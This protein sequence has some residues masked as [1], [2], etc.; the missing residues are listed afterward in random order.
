MK[1]KWNPPWK[2]VP[3]TSFFPEPGVGNAFSTCPGSPP[4]CSNTE[5]PLKTYV[6][7]CPLRIQASAIWSI[8]GSSTEPGAGH[9]V[10]TQQMIV[11]VIFYEG[12]KFRI[13]IPM[14]INVIRILLLSGKKI[15]KQGKEKM[16]NSQQD[17]TILHFH[18]PLF[19]FSSRGALSGIISN[20]LSAL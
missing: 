5:A 11:Q 4:L 13:C 9:L 18:Y 3:N 7:V 12:Y 6:W 20:K 10:F 15:F 8:P 1:L 16:P 19:Y 17:V 14:K 2:A